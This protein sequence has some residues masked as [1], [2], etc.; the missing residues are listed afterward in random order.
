MR[1]GV[2]TRIVLAAVIFASLGGVAASRLSH[3]RSRIMPGERLVAAPLAVQ[4][5]FQR[6]SDSA[7]TRLL[8]TLFALGYHG[9]YAWDEKT[10]AVRA[11]LI[12][13]TDSGSVA[14]SVNGVYEGTMSLDLHHDT[15]TDIPGSIT[16]RFVSLRSSPH[17]VLLTTDGLPEDPSDDLPIEMLRK[18]PTDLHDAITASFAL[19]ADA[20]AYWK[21]LEATHAP[22]KG[23]VGD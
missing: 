5:A 12:A 3:G 15:I 1:T 8:D 14:D 23:K 9:G 10:G 2:T 7:G 4:H 18:L 19:R 20:F 11:N 13:A 22:G 6:F 17:W 21:A 16:L